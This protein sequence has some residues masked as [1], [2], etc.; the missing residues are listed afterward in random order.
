MEPCNQHS[1]P[2]PTHGRDGRL[3]VC[4]CP[5]ECMHVCV[6]H[7]QLAES[8]GQ[9]GRQGITGAGL[10][11]GVVLT[12]Q[13]STQGATQHL[14]PE[15]DNLSHDTKGSHAAIQSRQMG[16]RPPAIPDAHGR[17]TWLTGTLEVGATADSSL[18]CW[19][20]P[21][22]SSSSSWGQTRDMGGLMLT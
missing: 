11:G 12:L 7:R 17:L 16:S 1:F 4:V 20:T 19:M 9:D 14:R 18:C 8:L 2:E 5:H 13:G 6:A 15:L 22:P 10:Q 21:E 3:C